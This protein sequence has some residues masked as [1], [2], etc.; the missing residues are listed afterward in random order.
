MAGVRV[1][2]KHT[3]PLPCLCHARAHGDHLSH[4]GVPIRK[5]K[6]ESAG[7]SGDGLV[8][9][10]ITGRLATVDQQL[11]TR[12]DGRNQGLHQHLVGSRT[13]HMGLLHRYP[14][15]GGKVQGMLLQS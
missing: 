15:G 11:G 6:P 2:G 10:N 14:I 3:T 5:G 7:K 4:S 8:H 9:G 12:T 1:K 13:R